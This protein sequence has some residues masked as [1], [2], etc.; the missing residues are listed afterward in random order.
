MVPNMKQK[1]IPQIIANN[2]VWVIVLWLIP[3]FVSMSGSD[4][5]NAVRKIKLIICR[6]ILKGIAIRDKINS[7][8]P[9]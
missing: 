9:Q 2:I 1:T 6:L 4:E 7:V 3:S 5:R 8:N